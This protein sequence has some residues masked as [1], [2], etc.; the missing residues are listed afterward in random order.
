MAGANRHRFLMRIRVCASRWQG[1][2]GGGGGGDGG[3][4]GDGGEAEKEEPQLTPTATILAL[5]QM[6]KH[7]WAQAK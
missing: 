2:A 4:G 7:A 5:M 1:A 3:D 6:D